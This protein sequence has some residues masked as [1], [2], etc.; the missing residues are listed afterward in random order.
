MTRYCSVG[1]LPSAEGV[2]PL[3]IHGRVQHARGDYGAVV[4]IECDEAAVEGAVVQRV[5]QE[6]VRRHELLTCGYRYPRSAEACR[7]Q[8]GDV[9]VHEIADAAMAGKK[10]P[11]PQF[12]CCWTFEFRFVRALVLPWTWLHSD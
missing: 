10:Y 8:G 3:V 6:A 12:F 2:E 1:R 9:N 11:K 7:E 4:V 5:E